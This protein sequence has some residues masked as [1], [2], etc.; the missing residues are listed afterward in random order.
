MEEEL[1]KDEEEDERNGRNHQGARGALGLRRDQESQP[2]RGGPVLRGEAG[3][4]GG[5][6]KD[7][8]RWKAELRQGLRSPTGSA[9]PRQGG[10]RGSGR[11][12][13]GEAPQGE[14]QP[15]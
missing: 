12:G 1:R 14:Q 8:R 11:S 13:G 6:R 4:G 2:H 3:R 9:A 10:S 15:H 5:I 7:Q